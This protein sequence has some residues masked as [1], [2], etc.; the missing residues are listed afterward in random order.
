M[1]R[2]MVKFYSRKVFF[3]EFFVINKKLLSIVIGIL[4]LIDEW[5]DSCLSDSFIFFEERKDLLIGV[6]EVIGR[7]NCDFGLFLDY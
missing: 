4:M 7:E 6:V 2:C 1:K 5:N 3:V